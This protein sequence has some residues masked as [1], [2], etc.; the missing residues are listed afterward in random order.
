M[1]GWTR[2]ELAERSKV[3]AATLAD[4][5]AGKRVPYDRTLADIRRALEEGGIEFIPENGGGP[6][7]RLRKKESNG[8]PSKSTKGDASKAA[9]LA[10]REIEKLSDKTATG[11]ERASR[12]RRLIAGPKEFR[13]IRR[14]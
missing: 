7:A 13:G 10:A 11:E 8:K 4:F 1:L 5:E 3:S 6:G 2:D 12:K 14:K 9:D